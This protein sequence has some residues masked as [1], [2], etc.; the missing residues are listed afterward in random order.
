MNDYSIDQEVATAFNRDSD[1]LAQYASIFDV[2]SLNPFALFIVD[3][4]D[5][6]DPAPETRKAYYLL[7]DRWTQHMTRA[8]RH[9]ACPNIG[10][11]QRFYDYWVGR[12]L[13]P[14]TVGTKLKRLGRIYRYFQAHPALPH[15]P[16]YDPFALVIETTDF[17]RESPKK[18]HRIPLTDLREIVADVT[19]LRNR[20]IICLQLK[21]GLRA[22]EVVNLQIQDI[23]LAVEGGLF[24][25]TYAE[26][27]THN[28]VRPHEEALYVASR[29][30]RQKNKSQCPRILPIGRELRS[31]LIRY[32]LIRP[33]TNAD[34]LLLGI[35]TH[36]PITAETVGRVWR[37]AF[38]PEYRETGEYRAVTSHFG[39]HYFTTHWR[40]KQGLNRELLKYMRGDTTADWLNRPQDALDQYIHTYYEDVEQV[41][42]DGI[43]SLFN[44]ASM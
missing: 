27:G 34:E 13:K 10:H 2:L 33:D 7:I 12:G 16:G 40:V 42:R 8:G 15:P 25:E 3:V 23:H 6:D 41:Y 35:P 24:S 39:R 32:L 18:P 31:L 14:D 30:E 38:L 22:S 4:L 20:L 17:S 37:E 19:H 21:L 1:P 44:T 26:L 36:R 9:P 11:V 5:V 43:F 28:R 29:D